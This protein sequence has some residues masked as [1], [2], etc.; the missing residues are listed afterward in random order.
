MIIEYENTFDGLLSALYTY[1]TCQDI[2]IINSLSMPGL[3]KADK[4]KINFENAKK[5]GNKIISKFGIEAYENIYFA[6][7]YDAIDK[8]SSIIQYI[9]FLINKNNNN[10][11]AYFKIAKYRKEILNT[12]MRFQGF[13][14][15]SDI[16]GVMYAKY[17]PEYDI[18]FLL[19]D[20]FMQR[21]NGSDFIIHDLKRDLLLFYKNQEKV[22]I[23]INK[24]IFSDYNN[25]NEQYI[26]NLFK[27]YFDSTSI[28]EREN[29]KLQRN[30]F[31]LKYRHNAFEFDEG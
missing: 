30:M 21:L 24:N 16:C 25:A 15:F 10:N 7:I 20:Y 27:T 5:F 13:L 4:Q 2:T 23:S 1:Y 8:E 18:T 12:I 11:T 28:K 14:R 31:P 9:N 29:Y 26:Q 3:F 17:E 19:S 6:F 22:I